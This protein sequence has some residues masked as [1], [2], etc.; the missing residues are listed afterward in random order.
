[1]HCT[2]PSSRHAARLASA[3]LLPPM[4][5]RA[6]AG[7]MVWVRCCYCRRRHYRKTL[8]AR[9]PS[10]NY[11]DDSPVFPKDRRLAAAFLEGGLDAERAMRDTLR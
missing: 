11:L 9:M 1:M 5:W 10:L 8:L 6:I 7:P 2:Q 4:T 3:L